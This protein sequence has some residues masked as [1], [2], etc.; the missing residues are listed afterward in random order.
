MR[1]LLPACVVLVLI[2]SSQA[3]QTSINLAAHLTAAAAVGRLTDDYLEIGSTTL[4]VGM[5]KGIVISELAKAYVLERVDE[6]LENVRRMQRSRGVKFVTVEAWALRPKQDSSSAILG[7]LG[8]DS[9]SKLCW[10][11]RYW[12]PGASYSA[13]EIGEAIYKVMS[14]FVEQGKKVCS[15]ST[16]EQHA[17]GPG[18]AELRTTYITCGHKIVEIQWGWIS[19]R[20]YASVFEGLE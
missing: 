4:R 3:Q 18:E 16:D 15:I 12:T 6:N 2:L 11:S 5:P 10:V 14:G 9:S 13:S 17:T 7:T 20:G 1:G 8:F 19:E